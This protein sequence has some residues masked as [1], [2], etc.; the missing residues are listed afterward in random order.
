MLGNVTVF[1]FD[2]DS[3]FQERIEA[4]AAALEPGHWRLEDA[5]VYRHRRA[6]GRARDLPA[7]A[8]T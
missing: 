4:K 5:R 3:R 2:H 1:T 8:P 6:A 7:Q